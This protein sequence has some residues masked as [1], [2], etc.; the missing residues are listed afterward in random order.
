MQQLTI[1]AYRTHAEGRT[2]IVISR[3]DEN[4]RGEGYRLAGPKHFNSGTTELVSG[5][6]DERDARE[7]R[8][9]LDAV[10]PVDQTE[11]RNQVLGEAAAHLEH[12]ADETE[13]KVAEH[14]GPKSGLGPGSA[15]MVREA[16]R[17]VRSLAA[18][19]TAPTR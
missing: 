7:L 17:T 14:Y 5:V 4:G 16:A 8:A 12:I 11:H 15:D 3:T 2:Q 18:A 13:A 6:L 1:A 10:F 9:M 19:R